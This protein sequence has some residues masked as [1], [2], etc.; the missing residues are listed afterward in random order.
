MYTRW[1][2]NLP[3]ERHNEFAMQVSAASPVLKR[4]LEILEEELAA[5]KKAQLEKDYES[6][7]WAYSQADS[8]GEQRAYT[9]AVKLIN[10]LIE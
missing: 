3:K 2:K 8:I 5:S 9:K 10:N 6:S 4:L 7:A 1:T